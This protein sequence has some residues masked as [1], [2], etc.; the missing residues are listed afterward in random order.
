MQDSAG[1][2]QCSGMTPEGPASGDGNDR[3]DEC[4]SAD[5]RRPSERSEPSRSFCLLRP[6]RTRGH[7]RSQGVHLATSRDSTTAGFGR[8][9]A[10]P[11]RVGQPSGEGKLD[12]A[13]VRE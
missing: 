3:R 6:T 9:G 12:W 8:V 13:S 4:P 1:L 5:P 2:G 11:V 10:C 7:R